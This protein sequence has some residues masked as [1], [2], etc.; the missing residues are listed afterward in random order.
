MTAPLRI[1][2]T[3]GVATL[4]LDRPSRR[5]ALSRELLDLL[6]RTLA[7]AATE[8]LRVVVVTGGTDCFSAGA[9]IA[10]L[11][12]LVADI[13]FDEALADVVAAI[14]GGPYLAI[15]A[16]EGPCIGAA[17]DLALACDARIASPKAFFELPALRLS[18][19]YNPGAV[20]RLSRTLPQ[21]TLKR[22]LLMGERID[23]RDA[24]AAGI[25]THTVGETRTLAAANEVARAACSFVPRALIETKRLLAALEDGASDLTAW[26]GVRRELLASSERR[27]ALAA[28]ATRA[29]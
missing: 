17:L 22:L 1:E 25:V 19:L 27:S 29:Q 11:Q 16:I 13:G 4:T 28:A 6:R 21:A 2:I 9:D 15:A 23:G 18:L 24:L 14:R 8:N 12:G 3:S 7:R 26:E 20:A 10:E 5:N